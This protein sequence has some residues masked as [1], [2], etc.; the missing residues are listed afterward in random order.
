MSAGSLKKKTVLDRCFGAVVVIAFLSWRR[1]QMSPL[2]PI[3]RSAL[4]FET[5]AESGRFF[6]FQAEDGI[7]DAD[8]TGVQKCALPISTGL[9]PCIGAEKQRVSICLRMASRTR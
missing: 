9:V 4:R 2:R 3:G 6:F 8:V 5:A 1:A 7:R